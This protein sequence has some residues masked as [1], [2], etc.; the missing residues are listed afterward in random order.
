MTRI[1]TSIGNPGGSPIQV[2]C[3]L[4]WGSSASG[5]PKGDFA[6]FGN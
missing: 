3:W 6:V 5:P 4:E 1:A 2:R